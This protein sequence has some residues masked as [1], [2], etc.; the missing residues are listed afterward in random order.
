MKIGGISLILML[1][2][3]NLALLSFQLF[4]GLR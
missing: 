1:G 2:L 3:A 4:S